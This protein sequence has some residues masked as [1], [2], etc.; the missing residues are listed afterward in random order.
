MSFNVLV[1]SGGTKVPLDD[2]RFIGNFSK[3][4]FGANIVDSIYRLTDDD[5]GKHYWHL[6]ADDA[7]K[8]VLCSPG[9][10][11]E[12]PPENYHPVW[13]STYDQYAAGLEKTLQENKI[14]MVF[15]AAAVSDFGTPK[16]EGKISSDA[17]EMTFTCKKLPKLI[18][19]VKEWGG[20]DLIQ[21]GFKLLSN[22][23]HQTLVNTAFESGKRS[24]SNFTIGNDLRTLKAK[25]HEVVVIHHVSDV[26]EDCP[27]EKF[28]VR[29]PKEV[30]EMVR[31]ILLR[32]G[33]GDELC[34][35]F[36]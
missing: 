13:F 24:G 11:D 36:S 1:T 22:V 4:R 12:P 20:S 8:P 35:W 3:G 34:A 15:L 28:S 26:L 2:V 31:W 32:A 17:D 30:N 6:R 9:V 14:D 23:D 5:R 27:V 25:Q 7:V 18:T 16:V 33:K 19:K 21:V 29:I 10:F